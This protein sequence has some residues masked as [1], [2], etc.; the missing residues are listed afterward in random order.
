M[1][2]SALGRFKFTETAE[3]DALWDGFLLL[4]NSSWW[5]RAWTAQ[6][7]F[8]PPRV[9][10]L[11]YAA[12]SCDIKVIDAS[13]ERLWQHQDRLR[14]CCT[15]AIDLFPEERMTQLNKFYQAFAKVQHRREVLIGRRQGRERLLL[16]HCDELFQPAVPRRTG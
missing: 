15:E 3:F 12:D 11:H 13:H 8:L 2:P 4:A 14:S 7:A 9:I 16:Q 1:S 10:F 6:E 5:T